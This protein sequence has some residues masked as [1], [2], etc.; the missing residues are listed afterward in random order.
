MIVILGLI[1]LAV[2]AIVGVA[3]VLGNADTAHALTHDFS[4]FGYHVTGSTGSLF[5]FGLVV[6]AVAMLGLALLL[7]GARRTSRRGSAARRE[8][9]RS[10]RD[11][12][13]V[14]RQRD[15]L[16][17]QRAAARAYRADDPLN[18]SP[19]SERFQNPF[20]ARLTDHAAADEDTALAAPEVTAD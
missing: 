6:G 20:E 12:A 18:R 7:A 11:T 15:D 1:I 4:V 10:R 19:K 13:A 3:G 16:V 5:L 17:D 8:L 14:T 9:E 2:A